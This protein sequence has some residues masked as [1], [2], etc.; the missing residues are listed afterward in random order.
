MKLYFDETVLTERNVPVILVY[1]KELKNMPL[2]FL[3]HGATGTAAHMLDMAA[4]FALRGCFACTVDALWH[5]RRK[6]TD[7]DLK[8][9][10]GKLN[11]TRLLKHIAEDMTAIID[12]LKDD[13]KVDTGRIGTTGLS[14]GGFVSFM[15]VSKEPR[16]TAAA[17]V[18]G[19]P[20]V[21]SFFDTFAADPEV[22]H[23][24]FKVDRPPD[25][26]VREEEEFKQFFLHENPIVN[27]K[28]FF[29]TALFIQNGALDT[30]V[31]PT[32]TRRL[33]ELLTPIYASCPEKFT[34][35]EYPE[36]GH[37]VTDDMREKAIDWLCAELLGK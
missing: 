23:V 3:H 24:N 20:D 29:P 7:H 15:A 27:Y 6:E 18:V 12:Y 10:N 35:L 34:Y 26:I 32:G 25:I 13:D 8:A 33:N 17:P 21:K 14:Q 1:Q 22:L 5:G 37:D 4:E 30:M 9:A 28:N 31:V 11:F 19:T 2:V 16:I 36:N